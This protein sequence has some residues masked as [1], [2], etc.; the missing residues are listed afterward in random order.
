[1]RALATCTPEL[2]AGVE[3]AGAHFAKQ[4]AVQAK[5]RLEL[6]DMLPEWL[7]EV[8]THAG[9]I[10]A[11]KK[12]SSRTASCTANCRLSK[13]SGPQ[14][15]M[16]HREAVATVIFAANKCRVRQNVLQAVAF[17]S[18]WLLA[19]ADARQTMQDIAGLQ[20]VTAC[21]AEAH[22]KEY[23]ERTLTISSSQ[24]ARQAELDFGVFRQGSR[25]A[26]FPSWPRQ[27]ASQLHVSAAWSNSPA[28]FANQSF[29]YSCMQAD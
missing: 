14:M 4:H 24:P 22:G 3:S 9:D 25:L 26:P 19:C 29:S 21:L 10:L 17:C 20:S 18:C 11:S 16:G 2:E 8:H 7:D 6:L 5:Q 1:M 15:L 23:L 13:I 28:S 27:S 12:V